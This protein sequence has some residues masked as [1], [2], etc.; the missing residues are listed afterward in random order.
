MTQ[1]KRAETPTKHTAVKLQKY[2]KHFYKSYICYNEEEAGWDAAPPSPLLAV[3]NV[4]AHPS[5][6]SVPT[7]YYSTWHY[8]YLCT[9]KG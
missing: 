9:V 5:T 2:S 7:L 6:I 8:T 3:P 4:T 1:I